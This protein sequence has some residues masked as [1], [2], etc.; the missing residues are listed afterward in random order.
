MTCLQTLSFQTSEKC[1]NGQG[2]LTKN[3][4]T[5]P[6]AAQRS[7]TSASGPWVTPAPA[8]QP[9]PRA[10]SIWCLTPHS[11]TAVIAV[12][13]FPASTHSR[14]VCR[15]SHAYAGLSQPKQVVTFLLPS[16][17]TTSGNV[18]KG[19]KRKGQ[20]NLSVHT[21]I[22]EYI[23]IYLCV[24]SIPKIRFTNMRWPCN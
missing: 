6:A 2:C 17:F 3:K 18:G 23:N 13:Q 5:R 19:R 9:Q 16:C 1:W 15:F 22:C 20:I 4:T 14:S 24:H 21:H 12:S 10:L 8:Q 11:L 7:S